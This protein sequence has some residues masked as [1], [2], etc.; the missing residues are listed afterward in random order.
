MYP[1]PSSHEDKS[2]MKPQT[3]RH[4]NFSGDF[5]RLAYLTND[6]ASYITSRMSVIITF[7]KQ[8]TNCIDIALSNR[9]KGSY[10]SSLLTIL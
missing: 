2:L 6:N 7:R 5:L 1:E 4:Q 10:K 9:K 3:K 8:S